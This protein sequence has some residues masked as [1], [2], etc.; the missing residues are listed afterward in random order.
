MISRLTAG[1]ASQ[2]RRAS[3]LRFLAEMLSGRPWRYTQVRRRT[4]ILAIHGPMIDTAPY[5]M[6]LIQANPLQG[7][8]EG[9]GNESQDIFAP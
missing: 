6:F 2:G 7:P 3:S 5:V 9:L 4:E 8:L 1:S